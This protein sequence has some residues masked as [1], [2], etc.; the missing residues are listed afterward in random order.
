MRIGSLLSRVRLMREHGRG[1]NDTEAVL[2]R[3][4]EPGEDRGTALLLCRSTA[5]RAGGS[6]FGRTVVG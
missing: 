6:G 3:W 4:Q 2:S 5:L 1:S